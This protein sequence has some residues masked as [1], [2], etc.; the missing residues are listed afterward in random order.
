MG[1]F[2]R[3]RVDAMTTTHRYVHDLLNGMAALERAGSNRPEYLRAIAD[4]LAILTPE[5]AHV[6]R[7]TLDMMF[8]RVDWV[9]NARATEKRVDAR[10]DGGKARAAAIGKKRAQARQDFRRDYTTSLRRAS[11]LTIKKWA[12]AERAK[13][14]GTSAKMLR[15]TWLKGAKKT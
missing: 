10:K 3:A 13:Q 9:K 8:S 12:T 5:N 14:Y 1:G 11:P 2:L 6:I 4:V 7:V 15:D